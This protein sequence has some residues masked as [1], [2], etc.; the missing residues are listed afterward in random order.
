[1]YRPGAVRAGQNL[2][3]PLDSPPQ[4][5]SPDTWLVEPDIRLHHF[6]QGSVTK[7]GADDGRA[8]LFIHGGPGQPPA[9]A[10]PGFAPL[11]SEIPILYYHQ[12]GCG[13]ST[14]PFDRFPSP[15]FSANLVDLERTL[16]L[17]AQI[18]DIERIRR[19]LGREKL[20]ILGHSF[21]GLLAA[22]YA[23]E[24]P[25]RVERLA[26]VAPA[27]MLVMPVEGPD[28][29]SILRERLPEAKRAE[30]GAFMGQYFNFGTIF[31][32]SENDLAD[33]NRRFARFYLA[34]V[35]PSSPEGGESGI[36]AIDLEGTGGWM[37]FAQYFSMGLSHDY[38]DAL[39]KVEIPVLVLHG[40]DDLQPL[41]ASRSYVEC[42]PKA[43]IEVIDGAG[44]F[45]WEDR[46][47]ALAK[48]LEGFFR[49]T[50]PEKPGDADH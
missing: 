18:A 23:A 19:I 37:V 4:P 28:L 6:S 36:D 27:N 25:E 29:F 40:S 26:L 3:A 20:T 1:M 43:T 35:K 7:E 17:G 47:E 24:F 32:K 46:P 9:A 42:F 44:H 8:I 33:L 34:A 41:E 21:G 48:L 12:R 50:P 49:E 15:N 14:R 38:R 31:S 45:P 2:R 13:K 30:F 11:A 5:E 39:R 16:G 22:L 10:P